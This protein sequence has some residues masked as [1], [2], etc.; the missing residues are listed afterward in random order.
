MESQY[1]YKRIWHIAYPILISL[2]M[3]QLIGMTDTAFLG[4]VGEVELGASAIAG[5]YYLIIF[6]LG[7]GFSVG[8]Q[9]MIARR[10]GQCNFLE[11]GNIF[12]HGLYFLLIVAAVVCGLSLMFS[13]QILDGIVASQAVGDKAV[14]YIN[15]RIFGLF[16]SFTA[17]MFRAFYVGTTQT[18]T[19]TL[20]SV[21][22]VLSNV[23]FNYIFIFGKLGVPAL[24]IAGAAIGS[25]LAEMIS[26][27]FFVIYTMRR[28]DYRKYGLN[29]FIRFRWNELKMILNVSVWTMIQNFISI[30]TWFLFFIFIEHLGERSLA[31]TNI[32]RNVSAI[33]FMIIMAFAST[34]SS[35]ISN[36]IGAGHTDEVRNT[37]RKH[38]IL[39]Y[40]IVL[41]ISVLFCLFPQLT[42]SIYTDI[43]DLQLASVN[44]LWVLCSSYLVTVPAF[45]FFNS[46]SGTGNTRMA[47]RLEVTALVIYVIFITYV[48]FLKKSD[49][50]ICWFSE[51]VYSSMMLIL[52]YR[53]IASGKW[54]FTKI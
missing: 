15:W 34:C 53:Y 3:E 25:T 10:N 33:P 1:S 41:P 42:A 8:A 16:F 40:S 30:A 17:A 18:K 24:G 52:S 5:I 2:V 44:S 51:H 47:F 37:I 14:S 22:M 27:L 43:Q 20:N 13:P 54:K 4:R 28:V 49:V 32:I 6:M 23:V 31:V 45:I 12:Y 35:I 11:I 38:V 19:L 9:I 46:V 29:R 21:I 39:A 26:C 36:M 48:V 7:F 50:A